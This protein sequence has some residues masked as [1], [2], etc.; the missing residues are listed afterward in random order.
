MVISD[1]DK[2][3]GEPMGSPEI[4]IGRLQGALK[5]TQDQQDRDRLENN[6]RFELINEKLQKQDGKLDKLI[7]QQDA[8]AAVRTASDR[9]QDRR[10]KQIAVWASIGS[11]LAVVF[12]ELLRWWVSAHHGAV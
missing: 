3:K 5:A 7:G 6:R 11:F 2:L 4:E 10:A 1:L 12:I 8:A 9:R